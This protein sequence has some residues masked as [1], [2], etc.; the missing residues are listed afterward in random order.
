M[1]DLN[2]PRRPGRFGVAAAFALALAGAACAPLA[3]PENIFIVFYTP[4]SGNLGPD[5]M[6]VI[7]DATKAA[8]AAPVRQVYVRGYTD[9]KGSPEANRTLSRLRVQ[10]VRDTLVADGVPASRITIQPK[11]AQGGDPGV[12]SRRVEIELR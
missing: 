9:S 8:V 3:S 6:D 4:N 5:A 7:A 2:S 10:V 1:P 12:E 11:G